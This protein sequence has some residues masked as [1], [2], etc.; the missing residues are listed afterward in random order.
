MKVIVIGGGVI[1]LS[2]A[3]QLAQRKA[4][5][6]VLVE[7]DVVGAG[8][9]R[10]AAGI[11]TD[12]LWTVPGILTRQRSLELYADLSHDLMGYEF[13]RRGCLNLFDVQSWSSRVDLLPLYAA[14][15]TDYEILTATE[16][17]RRWPDLCWADEWI[18]LFD[19]VGGYSE[20]DDYVPALAKR[21]AELGVD[22]RERAPATD[23]YID[24]GRVA[25][26][27]VNGQL[28]EADAIVVTVHAWSATFLARCGVQFPVKTFVHQRYLSAPMSVPANMPAINANPLDGYVRPAAGNRL[29]VGVETAQRAEE[30]VD[31]TAF[32][33][34]SLSAPS[35]LADDL[36]A[37]FS[38]FV[39]GLAPL[40]WA[41]Q[42]VGLI[43]FSMDGEPLL[44]PVRALPG[45]FVGLAFHSGGFAYNPV[46]GELL[47]DYVVD[48][49]TKIDVADF[50][51]DRFRP[52]EVDAY[53]STTAIQA[54][55]VQ[56]RH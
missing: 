15:N 56:R 18:G 24:Q 3:Y 13:Q 2:T 42:R 9:S 30:R 32:H 55:A 31:A 49:R 38:N 52:N 5:D 27:I 41:D 4:C 50:A 22:I 11:I 45:L 6:V 21:V 33:M 25:G 7:K 23:L 48:G 26:V 28:I 51:P 17:R 29:L 53:L 19:P 14:T 47:A 36:H 34:D 46:A 12:L 8:A 43:A 40:P 37:D 10:R 39:P 20:P 35:S 54:D 1:G 44:G 16:M